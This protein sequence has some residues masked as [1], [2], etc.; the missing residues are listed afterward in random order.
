VLAGRP[1]VGKS[2]LLN[3]LVGYPRAIAFDRPGTTRDVVVAPAA[4]DGWPMELVDTAGLHAAG[5]GID[6][7]V[8]ARSRMELARADLIVL[9]FDAAAC[10]SE[11]DAALWA[12]HPRAVVAHN[13]SDLV[14]GMPRQEARPRGVETAATEP[15]GAAALVEAIGRRLVPHAPPAG[16]GVPFTADQLRLLRTA[17]ASVG[18]DD[19]TAAASALDALCRGE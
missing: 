17:L 1:N 9:V 19:P 11:E 14:R 3:A 18:A 12:L 7:E 15:G 16:A 8:V 4:I 10:W 5:D 13:K 2:S 6:A